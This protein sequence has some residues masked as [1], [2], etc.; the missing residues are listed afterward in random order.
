M[1]L[2]QAYVTMSQFLKV[3]F[4]FFALNVIEFQEFVACKKF[5][6]LAQFANHRKFI[7]T[8]KFCTLNH[9]ILH[10]E[11]ESFFDKKHLVQ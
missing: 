1:C 4:T 9:Q 10:G 8:F 2:S 6:P 5:T 11:W 3:F 7:T